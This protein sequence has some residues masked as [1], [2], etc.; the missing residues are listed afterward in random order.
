ME[1]LFKDQTWETNNKLSN[2]TSESIV[3]F[4]TCLKSKYDEFI[5]VLLSKSVIKNENG[6]VMGI[7][8]IGNNIIEINE[9]KDKIKASLNE[10]ELLLREL[11]HRVKNNLQ[12]ILSLINLQSNGIKDK[13]DSGNF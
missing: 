8:C 4:E 13:Q 9:A 5:P 10:K 7:V 6:N 1:Y 2:D 12:I 11:H 3:N